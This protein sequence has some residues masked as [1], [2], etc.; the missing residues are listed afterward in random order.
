MCGDVRSEPQQVT[1]AQKWVSRQI[2]LLEVEADLPGQRGLVD[3]AES[4][5]LQTQVVQA[6]DVGQCQPQPERVQV[7]ASERQDLM[8]GGQVTNSNVMTDVSHQMSP[9]EIRTQCQGQTCV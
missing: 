6:A 7:V 3:D 2:E 8:R 1:G 9:Q 5:G 4:V